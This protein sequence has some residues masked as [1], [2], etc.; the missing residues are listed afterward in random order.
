MTKNIE[1]E[2]FDPGTD[3]MVECECARVTSNLA[4]HIESP[5]D[6]QGGGGISS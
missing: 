5:H 3:S 2:R 6:G 1:A 4:S